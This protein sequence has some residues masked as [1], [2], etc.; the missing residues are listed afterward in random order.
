MAQ[1]DVFGGAVDIEIDNRAFRGL[2]RTAVYVFNATYAASIF[3]GF[4]YINLRR[5][6]PFPFTEVT[7]EAYD[8]EEQISSR[9]ASGASLED[10]F[11]GMAEDLKLAFE[12]TLMNMPA[13]TLNWWLVE[14][15]PFEHVNLQLGSNIPVTSYDAADFE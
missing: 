15:R 9:L 3:R 10:A 2:E 1:F 11:D 14:Y 6:F 13:R 5:H 12:N 8:I 4:Y 7:L